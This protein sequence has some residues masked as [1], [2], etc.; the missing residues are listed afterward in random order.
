MHVDQDMN[1]KEDNDGVRSGDYDILIV[2]GCRHQE[3]K[4]QESKTI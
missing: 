3:H 4:R 2:Q 1:W